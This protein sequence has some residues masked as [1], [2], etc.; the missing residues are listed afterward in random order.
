MV[1]IREDDEVRVK[2]EN[3]RAAVVIEVRTRSEWFVIRYLDNN[4]QRLIHRKN[5]EQT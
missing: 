2:D 4:E 1:K 3:N 5:L